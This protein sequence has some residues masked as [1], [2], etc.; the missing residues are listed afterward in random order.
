[1]TLSYR[2]PIK[3]VKVYDLDHYLGVPHN[4]LRITVSNLTINHDIDI[5]FGEYGI[6]E[7]KSLIQ[8]A[9]I[10]LTWATDYEYLEDEEIKVLS[11]VADF[12]QDKVLSGRLNLDIDSSSWTIKNKIKFTEDGSYLISR[13]ELDFQTKTITIK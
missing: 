7:I 12:N 3:D 4:I 10:N 2:S 13:A 8:K 6:K 5:I 9:N 11:K 1:M